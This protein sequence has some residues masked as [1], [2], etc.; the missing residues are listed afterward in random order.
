MAAPRRTRANFTD[1]G[2]V[3]V[4]NNTI[5]RTYTIEN[6]GTATMNVSGITLSGANSGDFA[7]GG[8]TFPATVN[9]GASK[10]FTVT[11]DPSAAGARTATVN[12]AND[13]CDESPY[14]FAIQGTGVLADYNVTTSGGAVV[15]TN[16]IQ[17]SDT[18]DLSEP[19]A[20][21][22]KIAAGGRVF[23]VDNSNAITGDG[24]NIPL[25]GISSITLNAG[26]GS[27][28]INIGGFSSSL[29]SLTINGEAGNDTINFNGSITFNANAS[30]DLNLQNDTATPGTDSINIAAGAQ[31]I[32]S[33]TGTIDVNVSKNVSLGS[34]GRLQTQDG[35]LAVRANQQSS[36][37]STGDFAG[38]ALNG[39]FINTT[40]AGTVTVIGKGG[41]AANN[42]FGVA[43]KASGA[44]AST[45]G[46]AITITGT[47]GP[48]SG[49]RNVGVRIDS[50]GSVTAIGSASITIGGTGG[51]GSSDDYG[52]SI[53]GLNTS[54]TT[55]SSV[56][57]NINITGAPTSGNG[58]DQDGVRFENSTGTQ[59]T[60]V[61]IT[62]S[63]LL[64]MTGT[65][66][67][68][69]SSSAGINLVDDT[70]MTL[71]GATTHLQRATRWTSAL[72]T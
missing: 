19:S 59:A 27:S 61:N 55:I 18:L 41:N 48:G 54:G 23:L 24:G 68:F 72:P 8:I 43:V 71:N 58:G 11:F 44:I 15:V 4:T 64:T 56:N 30:L 7:I 35:N 47:G 33:G 29:P 60:A 10:T 65:A 1:V 16:I 49:T 39:G 62:G 12:I 46:G 3:A 32:A 45:G 9:A 20:G 31:L 2:L 28:V 21:Q 52:V 14:D 13:D 66:G 37:A 17:N 26:A 6:S 51:S 69:V 67:N 42:Q 25:S 57:G 5:T 70:S 40:G 36:A 63:G 53:D 22:I 38:V 34:G 50:G